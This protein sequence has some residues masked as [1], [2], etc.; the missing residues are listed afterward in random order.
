MCPMACSTPGSRGD[1][2]HRAGARHAGV[3]RP[4]RR[5]RQRRVLVGGH[6]G[7]AADA[8]RRDRRGHRDRVVAARQ[9][10]PD[11]RHRPRV[12]HPAH[13]QRDRASGRVEEDEARKHRAPPQ[14]GRGWARSDASTPIPTS[15][16]ILHLLAV[17][18][19]QSGV[20]KNP[21]PGDWPLPVLVKT[22]EP[23]TALCCC[24][25]RRAR[26][27]SLPWCCRLGP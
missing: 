7:Q 24:R 4:A 20:S 26:C 17:L 12:E 18:Y 19:L 27:L 5:Q 16:S 9:P 23:G 14:G 6:R 3:L 11:H 10:A 15:S 22:G 21:R 1:D 2:R 25:I 8:G 13:R